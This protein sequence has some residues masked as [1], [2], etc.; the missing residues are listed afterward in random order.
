MTLI[1]G[2]PTCL[3]HSLN[4]RLVM[5]MTGTLTYGSEVR[6]IISVSVSLAQGL[7]LWTHDA[8]RAHRRQSPLAIAPHCNPAVALPGGRYSLPL[9][10]S[11]PNIKLPPT[12]DTKD[13]RFSV[14]YHLSISLLCDDPYGLGEAIVLSE[15]SKP[16]VML[17]ISMPE[18]ALMASPIDCCLR[19]EDARLAVAAPAKPCATWTAAPTL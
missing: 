5:A 18:P 3:S 9:T 11:I 13:G 4:P 10:V 15:V 14:R 16:F 6:T 1:I 8:V 17:P 19:G 12:Y 7:V 2:R